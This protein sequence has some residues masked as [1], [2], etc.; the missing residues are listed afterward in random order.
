MKGHCTI[1]SNIILCDIGELQAIS[2]TV[3][4]EQHESLCLDIDLDLL[5]VVKICWKWP[6]ELS[7]HY[8]GCPLK[9]ERNVIF[10]HFIFYFGQLFPQSIWNSP[11]F[12]WGL[13]WRLWLCRR[14]FSAEELWAIR[15]NGAPHTHVRTLKVTLKHAPGPFILMA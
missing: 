6:A 7:E 1:S 5:E 14:M 11:S 15:N 4:C 10:T 3:V 13:T 12:P 2:F 8:L 9:K